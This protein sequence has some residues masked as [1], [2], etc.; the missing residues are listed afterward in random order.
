M[1]EDS[2]LV[3][4]IKVSGVGSG[5]VSVVGAGFKVKVV[6]L[7][8]AV[9]LSV[10]KKVCLEVGGV[11]SEV[12]VVDLGVNKVGFRVDAVCLETLGLSNLPGCLKTLT[13]LS[14]EGFEILAD[15]DEIMELREEEEV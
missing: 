11:V 10:V 6:G 1:V 13:S 9:V 7:D 8:I 15:L 4:G 3:V 14:L 12:E 2:V 5:V